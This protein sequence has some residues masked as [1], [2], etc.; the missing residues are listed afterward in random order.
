MILFSMLKRKWLI[1]AGYF[2]PIIFW[3]TILICGILLPGYNHSTRLVSELGELGT[4]TQFLFTTGL[5]LCSLFSIAFII[6]LYKTAKKNNLSVIPILFLATYSFSILGA[7]VFPYPLKLHEI[8]GMPSIVLF[9]SPLMA[10][11]LWQHK[12]LQKIKWYSLLILIIMLAGFLVYVPQ[13]MD[14]FFGIKQRFFH[15]GWTCWFIYL[16]KSFGALN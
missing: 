2:P 4:P 12:N 13:V 6:G 9:L 14:D 3:T 7:A 5:I 8:L 16:S 15:V 1:K 11:I 10:L